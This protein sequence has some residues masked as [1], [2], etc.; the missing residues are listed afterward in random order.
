MALKRTP[1]L[2]QWASDVDECKGPR[3]FADPRAVWRPRQDLGGRSG[4]IAD[5]A[6]PPGRAAI[7]KT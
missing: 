2:E 6:G 3:R 7:D 4:E 5:R 1:P